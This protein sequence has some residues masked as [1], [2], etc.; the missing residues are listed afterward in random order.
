MER[1]V[2]ILP[3][4]E[5]HSAWDLCFSSPR[6]HQ[7]TYP[8]IFHEHDGSTREGNATETVETAEV[9]F[10]ACQGSV[11]VGQKGQLSS[12]EDRFFDVEITSVKSIENYLL[13]SGRA[14]RR[15]HHKP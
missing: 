2:F 13:V 11:K 12:S 15:I 10:S 14:T 5:A 6:Q 3:D 1:E 8:C 7:E 9:T 4:G